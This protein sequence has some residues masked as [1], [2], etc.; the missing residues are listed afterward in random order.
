MNGAPWTRAQNQP[1]N[2]RVVLAWDI[3]VSKNL[4]VNEGG[5]RV[6]GRLYS[7]E[8]VSIVQ[9]NGFVTSPVFYVLSKD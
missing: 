3:T 5:T 4:P 2:R 6:E 8:Y 1:T 9:N 7:N